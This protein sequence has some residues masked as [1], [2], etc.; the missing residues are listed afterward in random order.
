MRS[1]RLGLL[2]SIGVFLALPAGA[3]RERAFTG[4]YSTTGEGETGPIRAVFSPDGER[5]DGTPL[6]SVVFVVTFDSQEYTFSGAAAGGIESGK[7]SGWVVD[8]AGNRSFNFRG[9]YEDGTY[10]ASHAELVDFEERPTGTMTLRP[11]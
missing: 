9:E 11:E 4:V 1:L 6:W 2:L 10:R 7:L 8:Q 3:T 5:D